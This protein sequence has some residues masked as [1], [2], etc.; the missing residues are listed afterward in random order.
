MTTKYILTKTISATEESRKAGDKATKQRIVI[1][2][3]QAKALLKKYGYDLRNIGRYLWIPVPTNRS[4]LRTSIYIEPYN[5]Y[6]L[7]NN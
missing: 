4:G 2:R 5:S 3:E 7:E 1:A 6:I